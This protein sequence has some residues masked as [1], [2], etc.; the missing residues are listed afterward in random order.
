[1][2]VHV[3][4]LESEWFKNFDT[5]YILKLVSDTTMLFKFIHELL[6]HKMWF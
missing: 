4:R 3:I 5:H 1:M 2:F 6:D